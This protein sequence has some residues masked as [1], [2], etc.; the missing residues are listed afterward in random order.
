[1]AKLL[2][3]SIGLGQG[4]AS[5]PDTYEAYQRHFKEVR[6]LACGRGRGRG[7]GGWRGWASRLA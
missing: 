5:D 2:H 6:G 4:S 1:M 7:G 3:K